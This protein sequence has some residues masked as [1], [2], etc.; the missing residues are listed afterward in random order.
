MV[1]YDEDSIERIL[2]E[3]KNVAVVGISDKEDRDSFRVAQ[4]LRG[5]GYNVIPVNPKFSEWNGIKSYPDLSSI[6]SDIH[7][8]IVDIFRKSDSVTPIV[9]ESLT[10][11]PRVIWMQEGVVNENAAHLAK[12][13]GFL[14]IM[15][16]C[17][18]KEH[19][20]LFA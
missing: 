10:I 15:D 6:P 18:M 4:Y 19:K 12:E 13:N 14:V 17:M 1:R 5:E 20:K 7:V 9:E 11:K 16:R 3:S 8:D 2:T